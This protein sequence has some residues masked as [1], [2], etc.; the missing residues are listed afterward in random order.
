MKGCLTNMDLD[1]TPFIKTKADATDFSARI[2]AISAQVYAVGFTLEQALLDE[3]GIQK[4]DKFMKL[5]R[6]NNIN[7]EKDAELKEFLTKLQST[8][9][10]LP[11]LT[12]TIAFEPKAK[13]LQALSEWFVMNIKKHMLFEITVDPKL[14]AGATINYKG[15]YMDASIKPVFDKMLIELLAPP[16]APAKQV[17][18]PVQQATPQQSVQ[19][20][21]AGN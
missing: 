17:P 5:L 13:T 15:K 4:K 9:Q 11:V 20:V 6:D 2:A 14:I 18:P 3:F 12:L 8:A 7:I 10:S 19:A 1:L 21:P 16:P